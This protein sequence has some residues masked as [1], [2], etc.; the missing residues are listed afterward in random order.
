MAVRSDGGLDV[1]I[2]SVWDAF[3]FGL[4]GLAVAAFL[5][6]TLGVARLGSAWPLF[7]VSVGSLVVSLAPMGGFDPLGSLPL[8]AQQWLYSVI[9]LIPLSM[10]VSDMIW[11][12]SHR[13][14]SRPSL[15]DV[16]RERVK[17]T[18]SALDRASTSCFTVGV[19]TP[20]VGWFLDVG[21]MASRNSPWLMSGMIAFWS[22]AAIWLHL[23]ARRH[24]RGL[25]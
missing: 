8:R 10:I 17:L 4:T 24:L 9:G 15:D 3:A 19:A 12:R 25:K 16:G 22:L 18:A 5:G 21:Q 2:S 14:G 23:E 13:S 7:F 1:G 20:A 11:R 6:I